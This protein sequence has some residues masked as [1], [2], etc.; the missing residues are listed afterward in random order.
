[1]EGISQKDFLTYKID[2]DE[3]E[4]YFY[5]DLE[6]GEYIAIEY[7]E[8]RF[9]C[10]RIFKPDNRKGRYSSYFLIYSKKNMKLM[11]LYQCYYTKRGMR[12]HYQKLKEDDCIIILQKDEKKEGVRRPP[13]PK[14]IEKPF[15]EYFDKNHQFRYV[16]DGYE[17][18]ELVKR[19][20]KK[21]TSEIT[22]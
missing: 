20:E 17:T 9:F 11:K 12:E 21:C 19:G 7:V 22:S 14:W 15:S 10:D 13:T 3:I 5:N 8:Y 4:V 16:D 6:A 18:V 2:Y 1:M